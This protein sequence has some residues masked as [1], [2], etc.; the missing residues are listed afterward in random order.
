MSRDVVTW[1]ADHDIR[2]L[3]ASILRAMR[4]TDYTA[5]FIYHKGRLWFVHFDPPIGSIVRCCTV[6]LL[7]CFLIVDIH[8]SGSLIPQSLLMILRWSRLWI[9]SLTLRMYQWGSQYQYAWLLSKLESHGR[10]SR[11]RPQKRLSSRCVL[12]IYPCSVFRSFPSLLSLFPDI[13]FAALTS[14]LNDYAILAAAG[15]RVS[16]RRTK[17]DR[18]VLS[19]FKTVLSLA[20][21]GSGEQASILL[22]QK[23]ITVVD[24]NNATG[25]LVGA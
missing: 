23:S 2:L 8:F 10:R 14:N 19:D 9:A 11:G 3:T 13:D 16:F 22:G 17:C 12:V 25:S 4:S 5:P 15:S 6:Y 20:V 7:L 18:S 24:L 21:L 1:D